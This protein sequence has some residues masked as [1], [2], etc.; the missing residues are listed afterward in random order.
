[1]ERIP[2][3]FLPLTHFRFVSEQA[4]LR[5][6]W[7][8]NVLCQRHGKAMGGEKHAGLVSVY[9]SARLQVLMCLYAN[10]L[11]LCFQAW[12]FMLL[13]LGVIDEEKMFDALGE[14]EFSWRWSKSRKE[15]YAV[16]KFKIAPEKMDPLVAPG[17]YCCRF[18]SNQNDVLDCTSFCQSVVIT[19][20]WHNSEIELHSFFKKF[21]HE[22]QHM[23]S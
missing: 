20:H 10:V 3:E 12:Q 17:W 21:D 11:S 7:S 2:A 22:N 13:F 18:A 5:K 9:G 6:Q 1:M 23:T 16:S 14:E 4:W 15:W 19:Y 8:A